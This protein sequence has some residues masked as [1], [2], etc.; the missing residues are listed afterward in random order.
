MEW[1]RVITPTSSR[2]IITIL[3]AIFFISSVP[4]IRVSISYCDEDGSNCSYD[5]SKTS[6]VGCSK[7]RFLEEKNY[8]SGSRDVNRHYVRE[9]NKADVL[10]LLFVIPLIYIIS[11]QINMRTLDAWKAGSREGFIASVLLI[12]TLLPGIVFSFWGTEPSLYIYLIFPF[13]FLF[14]YTLQLNLGRSVVLIF[15][16]IVLVLIIFTLT[17]IFEKWKMKH[18]STY[19]MWILYLVVLL[20]GIVFSFIGL[21]PY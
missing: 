20:F 7:I 10:W 21:H 2:L 5:D 12:I 11:P 1:N 4:F 6:L 14:V 15:I 8:R 19:T 13:N 18:C 9:C 3:L 16:L 17:R